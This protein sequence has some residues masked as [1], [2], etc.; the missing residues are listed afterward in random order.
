[1]LIDLDLAKIRDSGPSGARHQTGTMQFMAVEVLRKTDHTYRHDLE[2]FFYVL[3]WMCARQ[4]WSNGFAGEQK[5]PKDSLL[6]KWE[7][8]SLKY[9]ADAK[10]GHMTVNSLE[11]IMEEFP[12]A[13]D[14]VK[15][16][17]FGL[18]TILFGDTARLV[19]GT[20]AGDPDQLYRPIIAAYD[21]AI[22]KL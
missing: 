19:L 14:V 22:S 4:A 21:E 17:C 15:P 1:M 2:S 8:G 7:I 16:L 20:P 10:E 6:R 11:R 12:E 13:L 9:I 5:P 3:L 18:R